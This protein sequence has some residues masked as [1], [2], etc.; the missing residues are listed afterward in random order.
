MLNTPSGTRGMVT[1]PHHLAAQSGLAVLRD[2]G[3]AIEAMVA[4]AA[5]IAVAYPH[6]NGL[7]G[8][9]FWIVSRPGQA[10]VA[11]DACGPAA[12]AATPEAYADRAA[13]PSR[14]PGAALTVPGTVGGWQTA[15]SLSGGRTPLARLLADAI[16]YARDGVPVTT[17][18]AEF[19]R[20]KLDE[21]RDVPG[22]AELFLPDGDVPAPGDWFRQ[23]A[24]ARTLERL[25]AAGLDDFYRGQVARDLAADLAMAGSPLGADDLA[26][27]TAEQGS[28][29]Q[30]RLDGV[31]AYNMTPPTQGLAQLMILGLFDR[32]RPETADD[33]AFVHRL[34]E[35]T[36]QA[37]L[38]RNAEV[39]DPAIMRQSAQGFLAPDCLDGL[40]A[41]IDL[42]RALPWERPG[43]VGDTIWMGAV[44][45]EGTAVSFIQSIYWEFGSGVVSPS[46]GV[47][48]QNRGASFSLDPAN[49]NRLAPGR[50]PFHTLVPGY[51]EFDDGRRLV[52]G[53]M[54]GEGQPQTMGAV[55]ARYARYGQGLQQAVT[56][57]RW[58]LGRTWGAESTTL[59]LESRFDEQV[60]ADLRAAGH[61]VELLAPF[62]STMGHAGAVVRHS[63]GRLEGATDPRSD[64]GVAAY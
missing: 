13:I 35:A 37:F 43:Q 52:Y 53:T 12:A 49:K 36:K 18:Q 60:V 44:D 3:D 39:R 11:I 6:M 58:L 5:T 15:L 56:A 61:A 46:T 51:A 26:S 29:L 40:A 22:F 64:G 38:V 20:A 30:V 32:V 42:A 55:F 24:L 50:K 45:A 16:G 23:P 33:F 47:L 2:G 34:V 59:K 62:S 10:P 14:G 21:L 48:L 25:A 27:Y 63:D 1:A 28:P 31:T 54:G 19:G 9:G 8:D 7:G 4:A 17:G 41:Q 57:P